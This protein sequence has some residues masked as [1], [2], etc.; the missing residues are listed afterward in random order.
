MTNAIIYRNTI[1][2]KPGYFTDELLLKP[3]ED[4]YKGRHPDLKILNSERQ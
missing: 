2:F 1:S 4:E 3:F